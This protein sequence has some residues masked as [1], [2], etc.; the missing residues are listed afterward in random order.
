VINFF[1]RSGSTERRSE[2]VDGVVTSMKERLVE[3]DKQMVAEVLTG[4]GHEKEL[5]NSS[6]DNMGKAENQMMRNIDD[7]LRKLW[8]C[9]PE[10][11][12]VG[13]LGSF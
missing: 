1:E 7:L 5:E 10:I 8:R 13:I 3:E 6:G 11:K 4:K 12:L 9:Y 2:K